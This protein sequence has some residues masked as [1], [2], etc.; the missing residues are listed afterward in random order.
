MRD[1]PWW[2]SAL[3]TVDPRPDAR[4]K[5]ALGVPSILLLA[6][7]SVVGTGVFVIL[8]VA[9]P[10]A[11]PAVIASFI[12]AGVACLM[13]GL[14]YA[15]VASRLPGSG[16][17]YSYAYASVGEGIAWLVGWCFILEYSVGLAAVSVGWGDYL[18]EA[19]SQVLGVAVPVA[20]SGAPAAGGII[21]LPAITVVIAGAWIVSRGVHDSARVNALLVGLKLA[22]LGF[23][24]VVAFTA[25]EPTRLVPFFATGVAGMLA[26]SSQLIF[27]Y[28]GFDA[29]AVAGGEARNPRRAIP[30]AIVGAIGVIILVYVLVATAAVGAWP[31]TNFTGA[32][33]E[34]SLT[35][36]AQEVS[37][38]TLVGEVMSIGIVVAIVSTIL[39][40][41]YTL[42]RI[43]FTMSSDGLL[44]RSLSRV[45]PRT[46]TP[47]QATWILAAFIALLAGFTPLEA[48]TSAVSLGTLL[49][50]IVVNISVLV[51]RRNRADLPRGFR[52]P[53]GPSIPILAIAINGFLMTRI[54]AS[55]WLVFAAWIG[56][57]V[58]IYLLYGIRKNPQG[59]T[60]TS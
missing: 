42:S 21:D 26:A 41:L 58:A 49:A 50:L 18:G 44:P 5:A 55:T 37:G 54:R 10:M 36:I 32:S 38:S 59:F 12:L 15:E 34:A 45:S 31:W 23:F 13:S 2:R 51:L 24:C 30:I 3:R 60:P 7:G 47:A 28:N 22:L 39:A 57:G 11:G 46:H 56:I 9:V 8:G 4:L 43:A 53:L 27:A 35:L 29:A 20:I 19:I 16:S 25:F 1:H 33:G 40:G 14:S 17:V 48:L 6:V 52:V